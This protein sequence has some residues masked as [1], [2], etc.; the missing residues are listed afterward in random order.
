MLARRNVTVAL[1][2]DGGDELFGGYDRYRHLDRLRGM[3]D[4]SPAGLRRVVA[5]ALGAVGVD[6][7]D[8]LGRLGP[9]VMRRRFGHRVHK[10]ARVLRAEVPAD[11]YQAMMSSVNDASTLVVGVGEDPVRLAGSGSMVGISQ[12]K[13]V[14]LP[15]SHLTDEQTGIEAVLHETSGEDAGLPG[16]ASHVH[17]GDHPKDP[18]RFRAVHTAPSSIHA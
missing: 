15:G 2:G 5:G 18:D 10:V 16:R 17:S 7:W 6:T 1:S 8:R 4:H 9:A 12:L 11:A 3:I 13:E 14:R